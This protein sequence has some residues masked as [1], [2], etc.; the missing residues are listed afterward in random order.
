VVGDDEADEAPAFVWPPTVLGCLQEIDRRLVAIGQH[1]ISPWWWEQLEEFY[2]SRRWQFVGRVGRRGGKS[3]TGAKVAI[4]EMMC[5]R[6]KIPLG[7]KGIVSIVS[8][9]RDEAAKRVLTIAA[10][11]KALG[12]KHKALSYDIDM[13][14]LPYAVEVKT[15]SVR[16][17]SGFTSIFCLGDEVDKWKDEKTGA[18]PADAVLDSWE[19]TLLTMDDSRMFLL[20]SPWDMHGPHARRFNIGTNDEQLAAWAPTWVAHPAMTREKCAARCQGKPI[21]FQR[22][23]EAIPSEENE[24]GIYTRAQL[25]RSRMHHGDITREPGVTYA[26][27][28]DMSRPPAWTLAILA[29]RKGADGRTRTTCVLSRQWENVTAPAT[30]IEEV[31]VALSSYE[32]AGAY[33]PTA[34]K[35]ERILANQSELSLT[36]VEVTDAMHESLRLRIAA[37]G[38]DLPDD[39]T[40]LSDLLSIRRAGDKVQLPTAPDGRR[41]DFAKV[42]ALGAD[43]VAVDPK[44]IQERPVPDLAW[45]QGQ[46]VKRAQAMAKAEQERDY[47]AQRAINAGE[48]GASLGESLAGEMGWG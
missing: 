2:Q 33:C 42:L 41:C 47:E 31:K 18:N 35:F 29:A 38:I 3:D 39:P 32:L 12:I 27:V 4:A 36:V 5:G 16:G 13:G 45:W 28:L 26:A 6:H 46:E 8:V 23:Y 37:D 21:K 7:D 11:L 1:A 34:T 20:S 24:D 15:A 22:E 44:D 40:I 17:V 30:T 48:V 19:P 10:Y 14:A 43:R 25:D 9:D